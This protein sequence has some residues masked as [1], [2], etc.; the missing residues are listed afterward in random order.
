MK[1]QLIPSTSRSKIRRLAIGR[2]ISVTGGA[3]AYAAL[4]YTVWITTRSPAMQALSLLLTFGVAGIVGPFGGALG[5]R[6]DRRRLMIASEA[7]SAA[8]FLGMAFATTTPMLIALAF[9]SALAE[10]PFFTASRAAIPNLVDSGDD[11][12]WANS[13]VTMGVHAGIAVGPLIGGVLVATIG[14]SWVFGLNAL[15]FIVS[16]LLT[17]TVRG[18]FQEDH[19]ATAHEEHRGLAAGLAFLWNDRVLRRITASFFVFVLGMGIGMVADASLAEHFDRGPIG[20]AALIACW[21]TGSVVG[22]GLGRF[23]RPA[24][25]PR[26]R[27]TWSPSWA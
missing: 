23:L 8:F 11:V 9:G 21:G 27:A 5:D 18:T 14:A 10:I 17:V 26:W 22:S 4:N 12:S 24:T 19:V 3:A 6:F 16:L 1:P 13:L 7:I 2:L 20:F 15:T 25:E